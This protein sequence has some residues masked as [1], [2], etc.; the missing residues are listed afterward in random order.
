MKVVI[1]GLPINS[2]IGGIEAELSEKGFSVHK[3]NQ[4]KGKNKT[5][6]P[7]FQVHLNITPNVEEVYK[8]SELNYVIVKVT[9]YINSSGPPQCYRC[10][11][12]NHSSYNCN[13]GDVCLYCSEDHDIKV[14]PNK[15]ST[16]KCANCKGDH[17][18][19]WRGCP[20][21]P[22]YKGNQNLVN[23]NNNQ[24]DPPFQRLPPQSFIRPSLSFAKAASLNIPR[25][26]PPTVLAG[27]RAFEP[28]DFLIF[29]KFI[30]LL[31]D[32]FGSITNLEHSIKLAEKETD[33]CNKLF[34]LLSAVKS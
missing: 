17:V 20:K 10:Q 9:K 16:P 6:I 29:T 21:F 7:L 18:A 24:L 14:C 8:L 2:D 1:R 26:E 3:I 31:K 12:F 4:M 19:N 13:M 11:G 30:N 33:P 22:K 23:K 27:D 32:I 34:I 28:Q 15:D 25:S 5:V